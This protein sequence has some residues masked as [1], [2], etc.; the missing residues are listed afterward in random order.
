MKWLMQ[1]RFQN[2]H[3]VGEEE[4]FW[5]KRLPSALFWYQT[6]NKHSAGLYINGIQ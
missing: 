1:Q 3:T 5:S 4:S 6:Q 2:L